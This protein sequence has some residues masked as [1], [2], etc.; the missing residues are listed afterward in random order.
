MSVQLEPCPICDYGPMGCRHNAEKILEEN[1]QLR[2]HIEKLRH[3]AEKKNRKHE[4]IS[5]KY[6][7]TERIM[8]HLWAALPGVD[9][10]EEW[11]AER[12]VQAQRLM[13]QLY[14]WLSL[15]QDGEPV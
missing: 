13:A 10:M 9:Q 6:Q 2:A 14:P 5:R 11:Q 4:A 12:L 8:Q 1:Q 15:E 3:K 7:L